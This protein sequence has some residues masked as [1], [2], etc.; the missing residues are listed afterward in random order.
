VV[1][2]VPIDIA[3]DTDILM[4]IDGCDWVMGVVGNRSTATASLA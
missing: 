3:N 1:G 2:I 4:A